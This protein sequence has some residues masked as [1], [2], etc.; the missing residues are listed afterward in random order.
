MS[1]FDTSIA[2]SFG[3][4]SARQSA[5]EE[6]PV[7]LIHGAGASKAAFNRQ[8][9]SPLADRFRLIAIDLPGHGGTADA[10]STDTYSVRGFADVVAAVIKELGLAHVAVVG[11]SLG[12]HVAIELMSSHSS[13]SGVMLCGAPPVSKGPLGM[14]RGF[15]TGWDMLLASKSVFSDHDVER[16][17]KMCFGEQVTPEFLADIRRSD[18]RCRANFVKSMMRGACADQ[19]GVVEAA[20]MPVAIVNGA[21]ER[22]AKLGY[23]NS[24]SYGDLWDGTCHLVEGAAHSPFW[25]QPAAFN[26]LLERFVGDVAMTAAQ[27]KRLQRS[28]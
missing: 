16:F 1:A 15:H 8:F 11:W 2:T 28:A 10:L 27:G 21:N 26:A 12:G 24:L 18:G 3:A 23:L 25:Q 5:G 9:E 7:L 19:R 22:I 20:T 6:F 4:I 17:G 13:V 14:L